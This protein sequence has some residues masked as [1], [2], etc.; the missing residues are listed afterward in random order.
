[1]ITARKILKPDA[2]PDRVLGLGG[3]DAII[4]DQIWSIPVAPEF[5]GEGWTAR[6]N[7]GKGVVI[8]DPCLGLNR[9]DL[10]FWTF[11]T[12]LRNRPIAEGIRI[13]FS[14]SGV[15]CQI[16]Q[17]QI[18]WTR[19]DSE[20]VITPRWVNIEQIRTI[21]GVPD[22]TPKRFSGL[23]IEVIS[24]PVWTDDPAKFCYPEG[25]LIPAE[26]PVQSRPV[27]NDEALRIERD[28]IRVVSRPSEP[29]ENPVQVEPISDWDPT[30][31]VKGAWHIQEDRE[32]GFRF[33]VFELNR[34]PI[35]T[36]SILQS[37]MTV[38]PAFGAGLNGA[39]RLGQ[40]CLNW[41]PPVRTRLY[42]MYRQDSCESYIIGQNS[43][44]TL[45][46][47]PLS[48]THNTGL[49]CIGIPGLA[50]M[51]RNLAGGVALAAVI[52]SVWNSD[53]HPGW[54]PIR[55]TFRFN[56]NG[57]QESHPEIWTTDMTCP[58]HSS[59]I[60]RILGGIS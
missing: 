14:H 5:L 52:N 35:R 15:E 27:V 28:A 21:F 17:T 32:D 48:N 44:R 49:L 18:I 12:W 37:D 53:W 11:R 47:V 46:K 20:R 16:M 31:P 58:I 24:T 25:D 13:R 26:V 1:M 22:M 50:E 19:I 39:I 33:T 43:D 23:Q 4:D 59:I 36:D 7:G 34:L 40:Q 9:V 54:D 57:I 45:W 60:S 6:V 10:T 3:Y 56:S 38:I 55:A 29:V 30:L 51:D 42:F 2:I 8:T 41:T